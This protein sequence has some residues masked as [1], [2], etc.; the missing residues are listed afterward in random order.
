MGLRPARDRPAALAAA[1][2]P[3]RRQRPHHH[4]VLVP[5]GSK[6]LIVNDTHVEHI[7]K[8]GSWTS[9][10]TAVTAAEPG[11]PVLHN[12]DSTGGSLEIGPFTTAG[13]FHIYCI[14]HAGMNLTIVVQ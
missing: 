3:E 12:L 5:K 13:T 4:G 10:G 2:V 1:V 8:N 9:S 11:A 14:I 7:L 6:L